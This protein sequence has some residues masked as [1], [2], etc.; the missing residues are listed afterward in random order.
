M[1][2]EE[3][4]ADDDAEDADDASDSVDGRL[5]GVSGCGCG[6]GRWHNAGRVVSVA[7]LLSCG[8]AAAATTALFGRFDGVRKALPAT[9]A[10]GVRATTGGVDRTDTGDCNAAE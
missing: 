5:R 6:C 1:R 7:S 4:Q 2:G 9:T 3:E 8:A 10:G